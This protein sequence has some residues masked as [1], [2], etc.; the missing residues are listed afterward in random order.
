MALVATRGKLRC[1]VIRIA[2]ALEIRRMARVAI[3]RHRLELAIGGTFVAGI[4]I[5]ASVGSR[6]RKAI[7]VLLHLL[8]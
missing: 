2:R 6:Q 4:A 8:D 5:H 7:V 3:R 1:H